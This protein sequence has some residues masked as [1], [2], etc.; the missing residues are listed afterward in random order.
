MR[1]LAALESVWVLYALGLG[2]FSTQ[3]RVLPPH[4]EIEQTIST[5][6]A[7]NPTSTIPS[8]SSTVYS[9]GSTASQLA[10]AFVS[11]SATSA[12]PSASAP[13]NND[14]QDNNHENWPVKHYDLT[15]TWG[16]VNSNGE[17]RQAILVNGQT[18][19]PLIEIEEGQQVS[20]SRSIL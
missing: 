4:Q 15:V 12:A 2:W 16:Q 10:T 11:T 19:G 5:V 13:M 3:A 9:A 20:V 8:A 18:P 7:A 14:N 6:D 1:L 17:L